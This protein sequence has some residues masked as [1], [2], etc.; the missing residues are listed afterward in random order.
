MSVFVRES[1]ICECVCVR[2]RLCAFSV[3]VCACVCVCEREREFEC[4]VGCMHGV[5]AHKNNNNM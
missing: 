4:V 3:S 2:K 5:N 1:V